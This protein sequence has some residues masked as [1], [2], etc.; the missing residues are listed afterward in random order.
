MLYTIFVSSVTCGH[1]FCCH[2][3]ACTQFKNWDQQWSHSKECATRMES[4]LFHESFIMWNF[5]GKNC[6]QRWKQKC[7]VGT[8]LY[9]KCH[10]YK[11]GHISIAWLHLVTFINHG[12]NSFLGS[13]GCTQT[14]T[15]PL[16]MP[17]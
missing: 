3:E 7:T 2:S 8:L 9:T 15:I 10:G 17:A 6:C 13:H 12:Q 14:H 1:I 16:Y 5:Y 11:S 4:F